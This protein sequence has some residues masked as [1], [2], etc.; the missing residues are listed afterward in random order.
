MSGSES[1]NLLKHTGIDKIIAKV[2]D[3]IGDIKE[4]YLVGELSLGKNSNIRAP[5]WFLFT[6]TKGHKVHTKGHEV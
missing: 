4:V 2:I 1:T 6:T 3:N 5:L